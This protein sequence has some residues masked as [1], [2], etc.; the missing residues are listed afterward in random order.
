[1]AVAH[2][3]DSITLSDFAHPQNGSRKL[4]HSNHTGES[5]EMEYLEGA[6]MKP[7]RG[8]IALLEAF[9]LLPSDKSEVLSG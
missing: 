5:H 1:V 9:C 4:W 7:P 3:I 6:D 2:E 8:F